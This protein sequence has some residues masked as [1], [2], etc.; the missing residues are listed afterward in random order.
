MSVIETEICI[1][2]G[3]PAGSIM[4]RRLAQLGHDT[5]L[6]ARGVQ[7]GLRAESL[8]PSI[9][10]IFDSLG[11]GAVLE[12]A[13]FARESSAL[14]LWE[15]GVIQEKSFDEGPSLL[16]ERPRM[17]AIL[18]QAAAQAGACVLDPALARSPQRTSTGS[19]RIEIVT[20]NGPITVA[21]RFFVDARGR[22]RRSCAPH[23]QPY[24]AA[25]SG[26]WQVRDECL[27]E[28]RIEAGRDAWFWGSPLP[29]SRY[30]A[31]IFLDSRRVAGLSANDRAALVCSV[32]ARSKLL[33]T[34]GCDKMIQPVRVRDATSGIAADL[35]GTDFIRVGEAAVAIDPLASQGIQRAIISA[36]QGSA[37]VHTLLSQGS[38]HAAALEFYCERQRSAALQASR[39]AARL[40]ALRSRSGGNPFWKC[41]ARLA[42]GAAGV[43]RRNA[44]IIGPR[45]PHVCFSPALRIV[46][47]AVLSGETVRRWPALSH[48]AL[49][50]PVA[51]LGG[52]LLV[53]LV[54][55]AY[56]A[57]TAD[58]ILCRW[59]T[60]MPI[61][62]AINI[63]D[64]M[65]STGIL[66]PL[67]GAIAAVS[68][69]QCGTAARK[70]SR[71]RSYLR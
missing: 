9:L 8:A 7:G 36:I 19:W 20:G 61:E 35:I 69:D 71:A 44:K 60:R 2:G 32:I 65:Y 70:D 28:T 16:V 29:R 18:S 67:N 5:L 24:T 47:T 59:A 13:V 4:A 6:V 14:L 66:V 41:R 48:P 23:D 40:Y 63:M 68:A 17:D 46:Q 10:P 30:M 42:D 26:A 54:Q 22:R 11:I 21:A 37:A 34:L 31:T 15:D 27:A 52:D 12:D 25:L 53:P 56:D 57:T 43:T 33:R 45:P 64:W 38:D 39:H 1:L 55:H 49:E 50:H 51:Y 58:Q 3:G 62:R